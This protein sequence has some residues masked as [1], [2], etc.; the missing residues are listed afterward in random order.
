MC[1]LLQKNNKVIKF[2]SLDITKN[3]LMLNNVPQTSS[4]I[5]KRE[6][7]KRL[8]GFDESYIRHQDFEFLI[9]AAEI[10]GISVVKDCLYERHDNG[11]NNIPNPEKMERVKDKFLL[12]FD[13]LIK[14]YGLSR[15]LV[16]GKNYGYVSFLYL[17]NKKIEKAFQVMIYKGNFTCVYFLA[18]R[19]IIGIVN[20]IWLK[21]RR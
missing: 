14:K 18:E 17:K 19:I 13:Y 15:K 5:M 20:K 8:N 1:M 3:I 11:V 7:Y 4:F 12:Q 9:R 2:S 6:L 10:A 21:F 16:Y